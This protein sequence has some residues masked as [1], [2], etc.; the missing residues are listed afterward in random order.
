MGMKSQC[1]VYC[2]I[3]LALVSAKE[4]PKEKINKRNL[5]RAIEDF[6]QNVYIQL[7][8]N[9]RN[10]NFVF[11]PL[12]LHGALSM[13]YLGSKVD[14]NTY[15]ELRKSLGIL[16]SPTSLKESF[17]SFIKFLIKQNTVKYG[18]HIWVR[19]GYKIKQEYKNTNISSLDF[20]KITAAEEVNQW[21]SETTNGKINKIVNEF[22]DNALMFLANTIYFKD[23]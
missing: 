14:S 17:K 11:S 16:S 18:N 9:L 15:E 3:F 8:T 5:K 2:V 19:D 22:P 12:S 6:T 13:V 23:S 7:A 10:E 1:V 20:N 4:S 21:V